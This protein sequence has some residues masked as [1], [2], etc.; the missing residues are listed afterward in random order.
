MNTTGGRQLAAALKAHG[1]EQVFGIPGTH[2][3]EIFA[4]LH[5]EGIR[6]I[7]PRHEQG[8]G[9]A[10]DGFARVSGKPAVLITTTGPAALNAA[11]AMLQAHSDSVPVLLIS[12]GMPVRHPG[13]GNGLLHEVRSQSGVFESILD[14]SVRVTSPSE[15]PRAVAH[16]F[17]DMTAGRTKP[18]YLE[19]PLDVIEEEGLYTPVQPLPNKLDLPVDLGILSAANRALKKAKKPLIIAGGGAREAQW[20]VEEI[21]GEL[22]APIVETSSS[23]GL[24]PQIGWYED[25]DDEDDD[26]DEWSGTR[27]SAYGL[28]AIG[29]LEVFHKILGEADALIAVGTELAPSEFWDPDMKLPETV[30]RVDID[31]H[32]LIANAT[33]SHALLADAEEA[34]EK[35]SMLLQEPE[36][37]VEPGW[38]TK[39]AEEIEAERSKWHAPFAPLTDALNAHHD[40]LEEPMVIVGD[41]T[42]ACYYGVQLGVRLTRK[43]RYLYPAGAGTLGYS[44]PAAI[45]AKLA[46]PDSEVI[47]VAGD[48]GSMFTIQEL[49]AAVEHQLAVS[50]IIVDNGGYGEIAREMLERGDEPTAVA[51]GRPDF[52]ALARSLGME[53]QKVTDGAELAAGLAEARKAQAPRLFLMD[54]HSPTA[55]Y[56]VN[57]PQ[58]GK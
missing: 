31:R 38:K 58:F 36:E 49:M 40:S 44:I 47:A 7:T 13:L 24:F 29:G 45:G 2:N 9:Y 6:V 18:A 30:V 52:V 27:I 14:T 43:D 37:W 50:F 8:G 35:L 33:P 53:A 48:G 21:A 4:G 55:E 16:V 11:T 56:L 23:L 22:G 17:A 34:F 26:D 42:M 5:A 3:L 39:F 54:E 32:R 46:A 57:N 1:I 28:G 15:I 41:S 25:E 20:I 12:P 19:V 10:A 51:L